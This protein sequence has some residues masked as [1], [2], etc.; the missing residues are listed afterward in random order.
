MLNVDMFT[1][2]LGARGQCL[3]AAIG[4][5]AGMCF[6]AIICYGASDGALHA[7][8]A[9]EFEG[10]GALRV[11][12]WPAKFVLVLGTF[13]ASVSYFLMVIQHIAHGLRGDLPEQYSSSH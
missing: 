3:M 1:S 4:A 10:E 2:K 13:L 5:L 12:V 9:N 8:M 6:F 7:F 11:P